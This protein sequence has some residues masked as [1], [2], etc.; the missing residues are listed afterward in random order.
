MQ[1]GT[2]RQALLAAIV[3]SSHDAI[4]AGDLA[5]TLLKR[6]E[7]IRRRGVSAPANLAS[8]FQTLETGDIRLAASHPVG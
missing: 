5:G 6:L 3:E 7:T 4:Y 2:A 8:Q 1:S